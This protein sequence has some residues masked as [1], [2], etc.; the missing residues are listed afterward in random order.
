MQAGFY[1]MAI[2]LSSYLVGEKVFSEATGLGLQSAAVGAAIIMSPLARWLSDKFGRKPM[3]MISLAG[4][5]LGA[6]PLYAAV[7]LGDNTLALASMI[8]YMAFIALGGASYPVWLAEV[9]PRTLRATGL[10]ISYNVSAGVLG[11]TTPLLCVT[12]IEITKSRMAPA[13][14]LIIAAAVSTIFLLLQKEIGKRPLK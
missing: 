3:A 14:L 4:I 9:F 10:G 7:N 13:I 6:W 2:F 12:L 8:V 1:T 5:L 11:G